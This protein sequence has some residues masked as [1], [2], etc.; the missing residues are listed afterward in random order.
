MYQRSTIQPKLGFCAL[1]ANNKKIP[2]IAGLCN[3]HYWETRRI[4]SAVKAQAKVLNDNPDLSTVIDDLDIIFSQVVRL[5]YADEYGNVECYT[6]GT[7]KHWKQM[8]CGHFI[9][10]AHMFT[11]F[12]EDNTRPQC[13]NCNEHKDGN[14]IAFAEHLER[15][16]KGSVE[17]LQANARI[18]CHYSI[19]ELKS[20][21]GAYSKKKKELLKGIYQ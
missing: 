7:V 8:Q 4:K 17:T 15:D 20:M 3:N 14:L 19:D 16:R 11:R 6:C 21:I 10:R 13:K 9:P 1:C 12:S 5:S 18:I 2:L